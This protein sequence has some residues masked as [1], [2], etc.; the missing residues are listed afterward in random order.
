M[1][2]AIAKSKCYFEL[3][4]QTHHVTGEGVDASFDN[5][6]ELELIALSFEYLSP[7][8]IWKIGEN[9]KKAVKMIGG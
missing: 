5:A 6:L 3:C 8:K 1:A 4:M 7:R 9:I 2:T